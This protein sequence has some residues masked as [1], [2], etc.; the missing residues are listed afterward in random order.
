MS[1]N[2]PSKLDNRLLLYFYITGV[3]EGFLILWLLISLPSGPSNLW[4]FGYSKFRIGMMISMGS[5][6][7]GFSYLTFN[8]VK[9]YSLSKKISLT[10]GNMIALI[11][12]FAPFICVFFVLAV[13]YPYYKILGLKPDYVVH[14]YVIL[15][16][17]SPF[18]FYLTIR[19]FQFSII[20]IGAIF[21]RLRNDIHWK[22]TK[23]GTAIILLSVTGILAIAHISLNLMPWITQHREIWRLVKIFD[24]TY[25]RNIPAIFSTFLLVCASFLLGR[26]A[27]RKFQVKD[28]FSLHW[29][30]LSL[31]FILLALDE[32]QEI[33]EGIDDLIKNTFNSET[34]FAQNWV[35]SGLIIIT[36]FSLFYWKF[37]THLP[38]FTR[39]GI[40]LSGV[41]YVGSALGLE[42][43]GSAYVETY[44]L[45][46][47]PY[48]FLTT[49]EETLEMIGIIIFI[50]T[51]MAYLEDNK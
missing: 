34:L 45:L 8:S 2:Y 27:Y 51:L 21:G 43:I 40:F 33:H 17:I 39:R 28:H 22:I 38:S 9:Q 10:F 24:L 50:Y 29:P 7:L 14:E 35:Y 18:I 20:S 44:G 15:E 26:I 23:S 12:Y 5:I 30:I 11:G 6:I 42:I 48:L 3:I 41:I 47:F 25:E 46:E 32:F 37:F 31:I 4:L 1:L 16:R 13:L 19:L 49:L 36:L